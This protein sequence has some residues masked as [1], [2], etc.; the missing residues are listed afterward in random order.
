MGSGDWFKNIIRSKKVKN[1]KSKKL[2]GSL[3]L[4][5]SNGLQQEN[6]TQKESARFHNATSNGNN[7]VLR[8]PVEDIAATRIQTA[9]RAYKARKTLR[10]LK[11]VA[12]LQSLAQGDS[13][14]KQ[15]SSTL[16][17]LHSWNRMQAEIRGRRISMVTQ[18]RIKQKKLESQLKLEAKI[19]DVEVEW[20]GGSETKEEVF[21]RIHMREE[22]A[23]KR[24]RA[25]AYAFS[26][27]W[28]ANSNSHLG[29]GTS[30]LCKAN[31]GWSWMD[32]WVAARPWEGRALVQSSPTK[33]ESRVATKNGK[34]AKSPT[35]KTSVSVKSTSPNGKTTK[36]PSMKTESLKMS[37][38]LKSISPNGKGSTTTKARKLSYAA[39]EKLGS[40]EGDI[41]AEE[42][43]VMV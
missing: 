43:K 17:H 14:R 9:Y 4:E 28:R 32:R 20:N 21:A 16:S 35:L 22:A 25:M 18:S 15:A 27:Q 2:K 23:G 34:N 19:H 26:H 1:D 36:S 37:V 42:T 33:P 40:N 30:E 3:T 11:G 8:I 24:E 13:V 5:K 7:E 41:R 38:S 29:L 31:W 12:R 10:N 39:A 6:G